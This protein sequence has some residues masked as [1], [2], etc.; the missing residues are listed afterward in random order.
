MTQSQVRIGWRA[1]VGTTTIVALLETYPGA[2]AAYSLR[3]LVPGATASIRVRR[4]SDNEET[5]IGFTSAGDLNTTALD[6]FAGSF[7]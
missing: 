7:N 6:A 4:S 3:R 5:D 1:Y 2:A